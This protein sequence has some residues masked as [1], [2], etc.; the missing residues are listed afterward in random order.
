[1]NKTVN[2]NENMN[3]GKTNMAR[4]VIDMFENRYQ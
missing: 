1:M 3:S 2:I 4:K